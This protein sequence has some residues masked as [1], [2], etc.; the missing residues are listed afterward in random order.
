MEEEG[1]PA[2]V[3]SSA[4]ERRSYIPK[5]AETCN[6]IAIFFT[7][8]ARYGASPRSIMI[9][10]KGYIRPWK[11]YGTAANLRYFMKMSD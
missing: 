6:M 8:V 5:S 11:Q 1:T 9:P 3:V 10:P 2:V 4:G 7:A